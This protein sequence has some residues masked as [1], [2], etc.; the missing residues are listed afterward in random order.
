MLDNRSSFERTQDLKKIAEFLDTKFR[1]PGGIRIGWDGIIGFIP[2]IGDL[3][4]NIMSIYIIVRG[5]NLGA[6]PSVIIRM[7]LNV[8]LDNLFDLVPVLGNFFDL[9]WK[10]NVKNLA[11]IESYQAN[12]VA[13][14]RSSKWAIG[15]TLF[16][17]VATLVL[18]VVLIAF[19]AVWAFERLNEFARFL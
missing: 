4:T 16:A 1:L 12:P 19:T 14:S 2:G 17:V 8:L 13:T 3:I 9:F 5:A 11:L 15:F 6:S 18:S 10:S 7:G